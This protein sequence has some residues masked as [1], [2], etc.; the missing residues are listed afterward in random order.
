MKGKM[1]TLGITARCHFIKDKDC[2]LI[3]CLKEAG[4]IPFVRSNLSQV[5]MIFESNNFIWGRAKNVWDR[6]RTVGGSSGGEAGLIAAQCSP[7]GIGTDVGGSL[8]IPAEFCGIYSLKP[9]EKRFSNSIFYSWYF[10]PKKAKCRQLSPAR[11]R[12]P[13]CS[14]PWANLWTTSPFG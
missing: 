9:C 8:R 3:A 2:G 7:I 6:T 13:S 11:I 12:S 14:A 10:P 5:L 4:M 1:T